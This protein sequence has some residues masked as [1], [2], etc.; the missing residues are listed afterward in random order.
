LEAVVTNGADKII[1]FV[2]ASDVIVEIR[3]SFKLFATFFTREW[4]LFLVD[5]LNVIF[6]A[7]PE[8][9]IETFR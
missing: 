3:S 1:I 4:S 5:E 2:N 8:T 9:E 6:H 7:S